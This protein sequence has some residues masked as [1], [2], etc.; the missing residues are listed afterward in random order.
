MNK[1]NHISRGRNF[2]NFLNSVLFL[3]IINSLFIFTDSNSD[4]DR[5]SH[6]LFVAC[7]SQKQLINYFLSYT[8]YMIIKWSLNEQK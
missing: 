4:T 8:Y 5:K 2:V 7:I 1:H 3:F 6:I